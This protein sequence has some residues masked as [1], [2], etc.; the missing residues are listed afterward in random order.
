MNSGTG[1]PWGA[2]SEVATEMALSTQ[3]GA[4]GGGGVV[5][6]GVGAA[7]VAGA[8][9]VVVVG[10]GAAVVVG[11]AGAVVVVGAGTVV[12]VAVVVGAADAVVVVGAGTVVGAAISCASAAAGSSGTAVATVLAGVTTLVVGSM[13]TVAT[14][15][16]MTWGDAGW[17]ARGTN[18]EF[19]L[20]VFIGATSLLSVP[21]RRLAKVG[22]LMAKEAAKTVAAA[23]RMRRVF[24][25][26]GVVCQA[27]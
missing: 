7:V 6:V 11:A 2:R 1:M 25:P 19:S 8:G 21:E 5:V 18:C 10:V 12:G 14:T 27:D 22:A 26:H 15:S 16:S 17:K 13:S 24:I 3:L 23:A 20:S 4:A 9:A